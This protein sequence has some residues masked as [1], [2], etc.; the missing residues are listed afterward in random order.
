MSVVR[1]FLDLSTS[2]LPPQRVKEPLTAI[3]GVI[4][5]EMGEYGWLL[6]VPENPVEHHADYLGF[7]K[8]IEAIQRHARGLGC[9]YVLLDSDGP[10]DDALPT[11]DW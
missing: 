5:Y 11:W 3:D 7:P 6:W 10:I 9:D 1:K 8:E 4:A 2:H